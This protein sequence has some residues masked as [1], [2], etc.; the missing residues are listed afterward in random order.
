[1]IVYQPSELVDFVVIGS[2]AAGGVV[3]KELSTAGFSVVVLEQ[4]AYVKEKDFTHD[5][6]AVNYQHSIANNSKL[7][8]NTFRSNDSETARVEQR[9]TYGRLVG[10]GSVHF[11][12][13]Y[14]RF[15]PD[16]FRERSV[17][18]DVP[19]SSF[20]DWPVTYDELE[21]YYTKAEWE[22]GISGLAGANPFEGPRSKPYPLPPLPVKSSGVLFERAAKKL[23]LHPFPAPM[24]VL[25]QPYR[26]R[27]ACSHCG[28]CE[29]FGCEMRA[30]SSTLA[31]VI[32][33]AEKTGRCEIRSGCYVRRIQS[34]DEGRVTGAV[35]FDARRRE[36]FQRARAVVLSANG[37]E[38]AKLLLMS[39]SK[40]FPQGLAN[41]SGMVGKNFMWD[42]GAFVSGLFEHPLNEYKSVQVSRVIHDYYAAD[43]KRGFY[44]GAGIDARF[45]W[46]PISFGL[47]GLPPSGP[48]WGSEYKKML[49]H[50]FNHT[51]STLSHT[52]SLPV[53]TNRVDLDPSVKDAWGLPVP[54]LTFQLHPDDRK[55]LE[56]ARQRQV[57]ILEAAGATQIW[58]YP[59]EDIGVSAHLMGT[60]R[61]G[62]DPARSVVNRFNRAHDVPNLFIVD[63]S[64]LVTSGR[65]Q[66]TATIQALAYRAAEAAG[67]AA[68]RGEI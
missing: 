21:P 52:T 35:Y 43:P 30:K 45:N 22:I 63:G 64:S 38:S 66:P 61:M 54:R 40:R 19:G 25:S 55:N 48:Q 34:N 57:E 36:V 39:P 26:G 62:N 5:E 23:G 37:V 44:G 7:Q 59:V 32:P 16:D 3:A 46:F 17:F 1:M 9:Y 65:Q 67:S 42:L 12:A 58:G 27:G 18:G 11:T 56:W 31:S 29:T 20:A 15:H 4:G 28:W 6:L 60:M 50:Y 53:E 13:N 51:F 33:M 24:A 14:W 68:K 2:G 10:G 47:D 8:P 49:G 41:S